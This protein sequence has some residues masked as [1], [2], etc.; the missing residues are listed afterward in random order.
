MNDSQTGKVESTVK[1]HFDILKFLMTGS[2]P[3]DKDLLKKIG[4]SGTLASLIFMSY[5]HGLH[6]HEDNNDEESVST[7][8][9]HTTPVLTHSQE[10]VVNNLNLRANQIINNFSQN[11]TT[12]ATNSIINLEL[13]TFHTN[14][15]EN[16][17]SRGKVVQKLREVTGD[18]E[19]DW[20]RVAQTE[21]WNAK[22]QGEAHAILDGSSPRPA[23]DCCPMCRKLYLEKD[24]V[25]PRVFKLSELMENGDNIGKK[26]AEWV[27]TLGPVHPSCL[28][29]LNV[30]P[31]DAVFDKD[32]NL[33]YNPGN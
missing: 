21:L 31:K 27:A 1:S 13:S 22:L 14:E 16:L 9:Q 4:I 28:C 15:S 32:G 3:P 23:P 25:T 30:K 8:V 19:R 11:V 29:C 33:V 5:N 26:Q 18:L 10:R 20:H 17:V 24:G 2:P 12:S 6:S 7:P